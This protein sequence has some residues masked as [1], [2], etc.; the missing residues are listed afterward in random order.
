MASDLFREARGG[1][2]AAVGHLLNRHRSD[3]RAIASQDLGLRCLSC[4]QAGDLVERTLRQAEAEFDRFTGSSEAEWFD[5]L[6]GLLERGIGEY[7]RV[8]RER[9]GVAMATLPTVQGQV[10][11]LRQINGWRLAR[12]ASHLGLDE[13]TVAGLFRQGIRRLRKVLEPDERDGK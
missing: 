2:R 5:W 11:R 9:L 6:R 8:E 7:A 3:L 4:C 12:I 13:V 1:N 10:V